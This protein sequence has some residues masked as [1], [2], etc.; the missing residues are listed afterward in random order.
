VSG[1]RN[2]EQISD[3]LS[4]IDYFQ[5]QH[6]ITEFNWYASNAI[7]LTAKQ[8][9]KTLSKHNL[10]GLIINETVSLKKEDKSIGVRWLY[11]GNVG[12]TAN[13]QVGKMTCS[14]NGDYAWIDNALLYLL[15]DWWSGHYDVMKQ[16]YM[17]F[18]TKIEIEHDIL[19]H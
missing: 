5:L 19:S 7:D 10:I 4:V 8:V 15:Q 14:S 1:K 9:S 3:T 12:K 16:G 6:F 13:S 11:C 2:I 17:A 18:K